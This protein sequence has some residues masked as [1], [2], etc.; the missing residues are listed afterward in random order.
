MLHVGFGF[1]LFP[2]AASAT[3]TTTAPK[4]PI[5]MRFIFALRAYRRSRRPGCSRTLGNLVDCHL[6]Q[7]DSRDRRLA[8]DGYRLD[9]LDD[10]HA[11][12]HAAEGGVLAVEHRRPRGH[13]EE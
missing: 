6:L 4:T 10:V 13:D 9:L 7:F 11:I 1:G 3:T 5:R 12:N 8:V 2:C